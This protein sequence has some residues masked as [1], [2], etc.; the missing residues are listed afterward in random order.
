MDYQVIWM[1]EAI[2]DLKSI[3]LRM[4]QDN[5]YA[6]RRW[7]EK[8]RQKPLLLSEQPRLGHRFEKLGRDDV[9][10]VNVPPYRIIYFVQDATRTIWIL[11]V[12]HGARQEPDI[13]I[14]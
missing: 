4:A 13:S 14:P 9:R 11:T 1:D 3:V 7:G 12:W 8:I 10:E 6:A 5:P 2:A